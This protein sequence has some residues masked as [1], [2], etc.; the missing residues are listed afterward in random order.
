MMEEEVGAGAR[1][2]GRPPPPARSHLSVSERFRR[3]GRRIRQFLS[4]ISE[5]RT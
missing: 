4:R 3:S 1:P 5:G 2:F